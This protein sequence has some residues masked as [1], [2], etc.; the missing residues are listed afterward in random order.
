MNFYKTISIIALILLV[1]CLSFVGVAM[2]ESST[3]SKFPPHVSECPDFFVKNAN[4]QCV[5]EKTLLINAPSDCNFKKWVAP[6]EGWPSS[7]RFSEKCVK[8]QWAKKCKVN[9]D[10]ITN[11]PDACY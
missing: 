9:W 10:G 4:G 8:Q 7:G 5:D 6:A 11:N 2:V 3:K 1:V